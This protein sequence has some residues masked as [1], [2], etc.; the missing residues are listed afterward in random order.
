MLGFTEVYFYT[1]SSPD[2]FKKHGKSYD[3][4]AHIVYAE[5]SLERD[6]AILGECIQNIPD[7]G[8]KDN[9]THHKTRVKTA[10]VHPAA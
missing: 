7:L 6:V 4:G 3:H 8:L 1:K 9:N 10:H 2:Y 5:C